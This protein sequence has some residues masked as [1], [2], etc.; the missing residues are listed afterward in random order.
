[1][2]INLL[3]DAVSGL[4]GLVAGFLAGLFVTKAQLKNQ[5]D[6][7]KTQDISIKG[8]DDRLTKLESYKLITREDL[9]EFCKECPN[10]RY[11]N[12]MKEDIDQ[13]IKNQIELRTDLPEAYVKT[14]RYDKSMEKI[15]IKFDLIM[16]SL[17]C[18]KIALGVREIDN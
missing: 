1:M 15:D 2:D 11:S 18:I 17:T 12:E 3:D 10:R 16:K 9:R 8:Q 6:K 13:I 14:N 7:L 4:M 5:D